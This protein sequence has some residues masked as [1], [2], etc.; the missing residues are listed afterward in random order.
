MSDMTEPQVPA[1]ARQPHLRL[2]PSFIGDTSR[3]KPLYII[4]GWLLTLL[5][6]L[7]LAALAASLFQQA[8]GP[9]FGEQPAAIL[10]FALVVFAPVVETLIMVPPLLL[11]N[12]LFGPTPA[13]ILSALGWGVAHSLQAP[14]WG[15]VIWWPFFVFSSVL[16]VWRK[17]SLV[18]GMLLVMGIHA[19]Q[20]AVP[21][22]LLVSG[23]K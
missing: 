14:M 4:K 19:M 12:R 1:P 17:K 23:I 6:S 10:L 16:L 3:S 7:A 15:F 2:L 21:T 18:T 5:P 20:N 13:V 8:E 11:L 22:L 9:D